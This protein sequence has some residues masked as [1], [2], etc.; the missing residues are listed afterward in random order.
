LR[1]LLEHKSANMRHFPEVEFARPAAAGIRTSTDTQQ[2]SG[3]AA[4]T[5]L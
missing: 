5:D 4:R 3:P 2:S 1:S